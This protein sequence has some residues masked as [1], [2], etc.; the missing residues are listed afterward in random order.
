MLQKIKNIQTILTTITI[1][2]PI[3]L[4]VFDIY[5]KLIRIINISGYN[6][7]I[8]K[9][10]LV[11]LT[12]C[13][14]TILILS[15]YLSPKW[16]R[17]KYSHDEKTGAYINKKTGKYFCSKCLLEKRPIESPLQNLGYILKCNK[18]N[19]EHDTQMPMEIIETDIE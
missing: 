1:L 19:T 6:I 2:S 5:G 8:W 4:Y 9:L 7:L 18:C 10:V 11:I 17:K 16:I 12:L 3:L 14:G 15:Y 13:I